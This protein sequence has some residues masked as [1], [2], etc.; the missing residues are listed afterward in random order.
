M[1]IAIRLYR[2]CPGSPSLSASLMHSSQEG[3]LPGHSDLSLNTL[4]S[5]SP[6]MT[7][8]TLLT[9]SPEYN[10]RTVLTFSLLF[11]FLMFIGQFIGLLG[12]WLFLP[13]GKQGIMSTPSAWNSAW[14]VMSKSS[15]SISWVDL[16]EFFTG[17][18]TLLQKRNSTRLLPFWDSRGTRI[19]TVEISNKCLLILYSNLMKWGT[20]VNHF[21]QKLFLNI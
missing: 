12:Y 20:P 11:I 17:C 16:W 13:T 15:V 5:E 9:P 1:Q 6:A 10:S 14:H 4:P 3:F 7:T 8:L 21:I 18:Q 19:I 2:T